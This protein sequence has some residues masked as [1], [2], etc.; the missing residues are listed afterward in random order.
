MENQKKIR[1]PLKFASPDGP[2]EKYVKQQS[3]EENPKNVEFNNALPTALFIVRDKGGCGYYRC[4]Q[5][6]SFLRTRGLMNTIVD[7]KETTREHILQADIIIF[8]EAGSMKSVEAMNFAKENGKPVVIEM[9]DEIR[10]VS[11]HNI[12]GY[13]AWNPGT[14]F[15]HRFIEQIKRVDAVVVSTPQ[16]AREYSLYN[17]S[18][19]V[20]P[21]FLNEN[22]WDNNQI[23]KQDGYLR[24]GWAGGNAHLD[25]LK[26]VSKVIEKIIKEYKGKVKFETMGMVKKELENVFS[27]LEEFHETCPKCGYQGESVTWTGE[28]LDNYPLVLASHGWDVA[29]APIVNTSFNCAK[30]DLKLKEYAATGYPIVA[31]AVTPYIEAKEDGCDVLLAKTFDQWYNYIKELLDNEDRRKEIVKNNKKWVSDKWIAD[32]IIL[33]YDAFKQ[34][35][36]RKNKLIKK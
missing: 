21:N 14:L 10:T 29:I 31:S 19:F 36:E 11:P 34:I 4:Y 18:I 12:G 15:I 8:Q 17:D 27:N 16:L 30:S 9:D 20:L 23:K 22:K 2:T 7:F 1:K 32:N 24:I 28:S 33:Y 5:P 3:V 6:A 35:I 25:D 26:L 13:G